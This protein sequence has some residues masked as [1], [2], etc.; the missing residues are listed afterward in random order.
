MKVAVVVLD[1]LICDAGASQ[2]DCE[3]RGCWLRRREGRCCRRTT[4]KD[5]RHTTLSSQQSLAA[6]GTGSAHRPLR[7]LELFWASHDQANQFLIT[8][9]VDPLETELRYYN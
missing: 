1:G 3:Q 2:H 6:A 8:I 7:R 5:S 9:I 4:T